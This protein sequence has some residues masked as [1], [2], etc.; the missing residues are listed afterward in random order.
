MNM[1][2]QYTKPDMKL[3][4]HINYLAVALMHLA[5]NEKPLEYDIQKIER[6]LRSMVKKISQRN[7]N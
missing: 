6:R 3:S 2:N 5:G 7:M 4:Q 1:S